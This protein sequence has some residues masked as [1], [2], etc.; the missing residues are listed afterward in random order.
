MDLD[1]VR[2]CFKKFITYLETNEKITVQQHT[3]FQE[4]EIYE[5][6]KVTQTTFMDYVTQNS[7]KIS[8]TAIP[9]VLYKHMNSLIRQYI[10][11][12]HSKPIVKVINV[13]NDT[14]NILSQ[15][16]IKKGWIW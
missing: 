10:I 5:I 12:Y 4:I 9:C 14:N 2:L 8:P 15:S 6:D 16:E 7:Q 13:G 3:N 11:E 1:T